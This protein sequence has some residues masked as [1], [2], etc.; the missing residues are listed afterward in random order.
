MK[1]DVHQ[2]EIQRSSGI[3]FVNVLIIKDQK[4][5]EYY[6]DLSF[7]NDNE[8]D[9]DSNFVE[10]NVD[11]TDRI[12]NSHISASE[13][14]ETVRKL[15]NGK[16]AGIG[17]FKNEYIKNTIRLM[18]PVYEKLFNI[19]LNTSIVPDAWTVGIIHPIYIK[20]NKGESKDPSNYRPISLFYSCFSKVFTSII[21]NRLA[22]YA[23]QV[24]LISESQ[25]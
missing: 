7:S 23:D 11:V 21:N 12:L 5:Y 18:L 14:E 4:L 22:S 13:I 16:S 24:Q 1:Y 15:S 8:I 2:K 9:H 17:C 3:L 19:I 10:V 6:K 20:K 25:S